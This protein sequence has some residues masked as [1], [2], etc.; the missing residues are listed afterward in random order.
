MPAEVGAAKKAIYG[1]IEDFVESE[2]EELKDF[3]KVKTAVGGNLYCAF[4]TIAECARYLS[5]DSNDLLKLIEKDPTHKLL[6]HITQIKEA[7]NDY[8][9]Q[10]FYGVTPL[11]EE[12]ANK[13]T[14][15]ATE[16]GR[17][18]L[19]LDIYEIDNIKDDFNE[20]D[21]AQ[22][23]WFDKLRKHDNRQLY[24]L[25]VGS[26]LAAIYPKIIL[27][28]KSADGNNLEIQQLIDLAN[29]LFPHYPLCMRFTDEYYKNEELIDSFRGGQEFKEAA[30]GYLGYDDKKKLFYLPRDEEDFKSKIQQYTERLTEEQSVQVI[31]ICTSDKFTKI[32]SAY[33]HFDKGHFSALIPIERFE[34]FNE[35]L[36][37][38]QIYREVVQTPSPSP[39]PQN[40]EKESENEAK[41][42]NN[43][44]LKKLNE[45]KN[46]D[47]QD[48]INKAQEEFNSPSKYSGL[49]LKVELVSGPPSKDHQ[50]EFEYKY[51]I[52][53]YI[54]N[55]LASGFYNQYID[56]KDL[57]IVFK[58]KLEDHDQVITDI[59]NLK[60]AKSDT[61]NEEKPLFEI[62]SGIE[63]G[64]NIIVANKSKLNSNDPCVNILYG[65]S[66]D[67][68]TTNVIMNKFYTKDGDQDN[69]ISQS[70]EDYKREAN[71]VKGGVSR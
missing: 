15:Y 45:S 49:G 67:K 40:T 22:E 41:K 2:K 68:N 30:E 63:G 66:L 61:A 28:D 43:E 36:P 48:P 35:K 21:T 60:R 8:K 17:R 16:F 55:G 51:K 64:S 13:K 46:C 24:H 52:T 27:E 38:S 25:I 5:I 62:W 59:R 14:G 34:Q 58:C 47:D 31:S 1:D 20:V 44:L 56:G 42:I 65:I 19:C 39:T 33:Y 71:N 50:G 18:G 23:D 11:T 7:F 53:G 37:P 12:L 57:Y 26:Y 54:E 10:P 9:K 69:Y 6:D 4:Y 3:V 32:E 70:Y 29:H